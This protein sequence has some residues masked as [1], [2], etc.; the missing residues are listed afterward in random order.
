[1]ATV[2]CTEDLVA[3]RGGDP[4]DVATVDR[5]HSDVD[6]HEPQPGRHEYEPMLENDS[7]SKS[8][9]RHFLR[10][11]VPPKGTVFVR[12]LS[13]DRAELIAES[14]LTLLHRNLFIGDVVTRGRGGAMSGI[15]LNVNTKCSLQPMGTATVHS[16]HA[17]LLSMQST[18]N[19]LDTVQLNEPPP[20]LKDI[21][22]SELRY[23]ESPAEDDMVVYKGWIGRVMAMSCAFTIRL[24]N[25]SVVEVMEEL[26]EMAYDTP[27]PPRVGDVVQTK[28][29]SL[30]TGIWKF[31][32]YHANTP[33]IGTLVATRPVTVEVAWLQSRLVGQAPGLE[34]PAVLERDELESEDFRVYERSR[35]PADASDSATI[36]NSEIETTIGLRVRFR[37]IAGAAVKYDGSSQHGKLNRIPRQE[38]LGY[39]MNVFEIASL[40]ATASVQW[41]DLSV[42]NESA[43]ALIPDATID[44]EHA[45]WPGEVAHTLHMM[46]TPESRWK[47]CPDRVGVVQSVKSDERMAKI[48]WCTGARISY[49][50]AD[51]D[52][53]AAKRELLEG[54]VAVADGATE[55][56]SLYDL[57]APAELNVRRGDVV[58]IASKEAHS[59]LSSGPQDICWLGEIIDTLLDGQLL[60]RLGAADTVKDVALRREEVVVAIR[61]DGTDGLEDLQAAADAM[62]GSESFD[63]SEEYDSDEEGLDEDELVT[64]R[65]ENG[66]LMDIDDVEDDDWESD[67]EGEDGGDEEMHDAVE[68]QTPPTSHANT[69]NTPVPEPSKP[70]NDTTGSVTDPPEPYLI[71]ETQPPLDHHYRSQPS[72]TNAAHMKRVQKEHKILRSPGSLPPNIFIR[73]YESRLDLLRCL[74]LGPTETPYASAPFVVDFYLPTDY[75]HAPPQAFFH[76]W[77]GEVGGV[78]RVNP[79]L[80]EDGK[81]CLSLLGTWEGDRGEG[82]NAGKSTLLQV[83]V[84]LLGLVLVREPY[85]NEA[86]Y[87]PLAGLESSKR[88]SA[89]YNERTFLRSNGFLLC[90]LA[91]VANNESLSG[92]DG[93]RDELKWLYLHPNGQKLLE[94]A[95]KRVEDVLARSEREEGELDGLTVMS[96]GACIA[97]RRVLEG[98]RSFAEQGRRKTKAENMATG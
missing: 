38:T 12:W 75:P 9:R 70:E 24:G 80:Y 46:P 37:D 53:E 27:N 3:R 79:N 5:T 63:W 96:K 26:V 39:D 6:T 31:G 21:P 35:R 25:S 10:D 23:E 85:F 56:W 87:E 65:N 47:E 20:P 36:S 68:H 42:T 58:L 34:P 74:I 60:V 14:E 52:S 66:E 28:K 19:R 22:V 72:T 45:A 97:L 49:S 57:D 4:H 54:V 16:D 11:G 41:Q 76:S 43:I 62:H 59:R 91:A 32:Q 69:P 73:T 89:L 92:I 67:N 55:D 1:M 8:A 30:R 81:I 71:L 61:S 44:D 84:S 83:I 82:W 94:T 86:G 15:V 48:R 98:L 50:K 51:S 40:S 93:L 77:S 95:T 29:G 17:S 7:V 13:S 88:P 64:Y 78:G 2:Y 90:A 18:A 33:P